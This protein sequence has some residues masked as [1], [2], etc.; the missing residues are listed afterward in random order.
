MN[1]LVFLGAGVVFLLLGYLTYGAFIARK[2]GVSDANRTPAHTMG[3]GVD[4]VPARKPI[5]LGH[6]FASIAGAAP[7]IGP[8][9]AAQFGWAPVFVWILLGGVFLG[10]VHDLASLVASVRHEGRSIGM[11][12]ERYLGSLGKVLFLLF[13]WATLVLVIAVFTLV[14]STTFVKTPEV[15]SASI[16]FIALAIGFG[17]AVYRTKVN[18]VLASIVGVILL[19]GCLWV[20][21]LAPFPDFLGGADEMRL[22]WQIVLVGYI[23]VASV[24]PVNILLQPRDYLNSF[25]LYGV[26]LVSL[27]A[28]IVDPPAIRGEAFIAFEVEGMGSI[29]PILFVT[30]ACG[31]ISGFHSM[32]ASGTT[33]KQLDKESDARAIGYGG[34]LIESTLA[35][36]ALL[37]AVIV[38]QEEYVDRL[39]VQGKANPVHVFSVGVATLLE[40]LRIPRELGEGFAG[41][42]VSAFALTSLD[43]ATRLGRFS[44]Q[45]LFMKS[46]RPR[47]EQSVVVRNRFAATLVTVLAG[48]LLLFSGKTMD[49]WRI[50]G[51]ANQLLA[52]LALMAATVWL[53]SRKQQRWFT[54]I[55]MIFMYIVALSALV[56]LMWEIAHAEEPKWVLAVLVVLLFLLALL[57]AYSFVRHQLRGAGREA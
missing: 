16:L 52:A 53:A 56:S 31:A 10:A 28:V 30:V 9:L 3:D 49:L 37:T 34:M 27:L 44:A 41:L 42:A 14:V 13:A 25:L 8:V 51:S 35:L 32:V 22:F 2:L 43:T 38:S 18:F 39:V 20:G 7:I 40:A 5:L 6:H 45:E 24:T 33:A 26:L 36:L 11:I 23:F 57:L 54:L 12:I 21:V 46:G 1:G 4:Y 29:F 47:E 48:G 17:L 50:F 15:A 19:L 55:P